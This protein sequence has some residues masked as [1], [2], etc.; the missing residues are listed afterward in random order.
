MELV[1]M[2]YVKQEPFSSLDENDDNPSNNPKV[3]KKQ[4]LVTEQ[5]CDI[6]MKSELSIEE[7]K[8]VIKEL[9]AVAKFTPQEGV[10]L[11]AVSFNIVLNISV[12]IA[13]SPSYCMFIDRVGDYCNFW[14]IHIFML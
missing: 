5:T 4:C 9:V 3:K 13:I 11:P 12:Y 8:P 1:G 10:A 2:Q 14:I 6:D 7:S